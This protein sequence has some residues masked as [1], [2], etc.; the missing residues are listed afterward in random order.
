MVLTI[1]IFKVFLGHVKEQRGY[2]ACLAVAKAQFPAPTLP[3]YDH[4]LYNRQVV[5]GKIK[6]SEQPIHVRR[7][8]NVLIAIPILKV[9]T[10]ETKPLI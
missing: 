8:P 2:R 7:Q 4:S 6:H 5:P 3:L 9:L 1:T 10:L